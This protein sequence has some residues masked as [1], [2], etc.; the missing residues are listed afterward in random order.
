M[1]AAMAAAAA[2]LAAVPGAQAQTVAGAG[3][4]QFALLV[5]FAS[6]GLPTPP[7][8]CA[9]I[10]FSFFGGSQVAAF[11]LTEN[12]TNVLPYVG[13][14]SFIGTG[15]SGCAGDALDF[16]SVSLNVSGSSGLSGSVSCSMTGLYVRIAAATL[17]IPNG[18]CTLNGASEPTAGFVVA[19]TFV[20][21]QGNGVTM[22]LACS[23]NGVTAPITSG[24]LYGGFV[25]HT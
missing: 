23:G 8:L 11:T 16:G 1:G 15:S 22:P 4:G 6:P 13:P 2:A 24:E 14:V 17:A 12:P 21:C 9:P 20:P 25:L 19:G 18:S 5:N 3:G 10:S 7:T